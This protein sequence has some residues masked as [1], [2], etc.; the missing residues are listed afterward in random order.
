MKRL[1]SLCALAVLLAAPALAQK[2]YTEIEYPPLPDF[3]VP[4]AT[5][6]ELDN[7]MI[8][9]LIEDRELPLVNL[10]ARIGVGSVWEPAD[11]TGLA[12]VTGDVLR[13]G[14]TESVPA[15]ALNERL[16]SIGAVIETG[17]GET[18]GS[19]FMS[20]LTEHTDEVL[21]LFAEVLMNPAFP[22][23][24]I[25]LAKT[26][27]KSAISRR[28]DDPQEI[29]FRE[30]D[31]LIYGADSPYART[32]EYFTVEAISREDA[33]A[34]HERFY[35]PNNVILGVWGD[36]DTDAM[37]EKLRAAFGGWQ[38]APGFERP[39]P[40]PVDA[41]SDYGVF[42]AEKPDVTQST[43]LL[44]HPGEVSRAHPDY[45]ALT[46]MN[47]VLS[48]GFS[49]RLFQ[50][51]RDD[52]GLA[53][54]VFGAYTANYDRPGQFYAGV[55]TKS[56]S[57]V[58]AAR[59]VLREIEKMQ[60]APPTGDEI[61]QAKESYLNAFVFNFDSRREIVDRLTTYEYYGYPADYLEQQQRGIAAVTAD[62]VHRVSQEYLRPDQVKILAVG[63]DADFGEPLSALGPV[64]EID[65]TIP[66]TREAAPEATEETRSEGRALLRQAADAL[67]GMAAFQQIESVRATA[68]SAMTTPDNQQM[69][70]SLEMVV[71]YPDKARL[72]QRLPMGEF[73]V[74]INGRD[75]SL[76]APQGSMPAP[77]PMRRQFFGALWR[78][79]AYLFAHAGADG[80][81]V[82]FVGQETVDG[83][84]MDVLRIAPPGEADPFQL[85]LDA[86]THRPVQVTYTG[87]DMN[88]TPT[89][90]R[91]VWSDFRTVNG[92][93]VPFKTTTYGP[94][95]AV[96]AETT[97]DVLEFNV[98]V[99][100]SLF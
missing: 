8:V 66:T 90:S 84:T 83:T 46:M 51:V 7:G 72:T 21:G 44:G 68:A 30:F 35:H 85:F 10:S 56:E 16:E 89:D 100:P 65:I 14:G 22:Q 95:G 6:L 78:D 20:T 61:D 23:D 75:V 17:I 11:K 50:N 58:E 97:V 25:D 5:R 26:Q 19:A 94:D 96:A 36:F 67:G 42:Y 73:T 77:P 31:E 71:A 98:P 12:A 87:M 93:L 3:E 81:E 49:S 76:T 48:G 9:Y 28:N 62:D 27:W 24:K 13:T 99:D 41:A 63:N 55:M 57:T 45:H 53:Y 54:A 40:P 80:L 39:A 52:Q 69:Q 34:F 38:A 64:E 92:V 1:L 88:G 15:D 18:S 70:T 4:E 32:P 2:H 60:E 91:E 47:Q 86:E 33:L 82:Q 59:S 74:T 43:V 79:V 37:V 29:A